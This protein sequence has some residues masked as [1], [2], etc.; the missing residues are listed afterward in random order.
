MRIYRGRGCQQQ[1]SP[2]RDCRLWWP[3]TWGVTAPAPSSKRYAA[4]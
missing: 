1:A 2:S 4:I 3:P